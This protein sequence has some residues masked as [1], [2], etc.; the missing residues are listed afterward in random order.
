MKVK[1]H[2]T[3]GSYPTSTPAHQKY[4]GNTPCVEMA[5][6]QD[7]VLFDAGTG[8]LGVDFQDKAWKGE[9]T[10]FLTHLH[11]DHIQGLAFCKPLFSPGQVVHIYGPPDSGESLQVRLNRYLSPPLFPIPLRDIPSDL[12]IHEMPDTPLELGNFRITGEY[13]SHPG[14]TLGYRVECKGKVVTYLPDHEPVI[15][16][17]K[18]YPEDEWISGFS[19]AQDADLLIHDAQYT[20]KEYKTK[21]GW[22]HSSVN[23]AA[24]FCART[25]ARRL[26][27]FHHDPSHTD[28]ELSK[29]FQKLGRKEEFDFPIQMAVQGAELEV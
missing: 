25:G 16:D 1:L 5:D 22:G 13:I 26:V 6:G 12:R 29:I 3:R 15:G 4:G 19:L 11:M 27:L 23:M 2:G 24:R 20:K 17:A 14:P 28:A 7:R 10:I 18:L 21:P 8:I 9:I